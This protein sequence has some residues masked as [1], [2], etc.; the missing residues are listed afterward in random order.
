MALDKALEKDLARFKRY[1]DD[2]LHAD[3]GELEHHIQ[4]FIR[5]IQRNALVQKIIKNLP[6]F[7]A[8][9]WWDKH[10]LEPAKARHGRLESIH[11]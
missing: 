2:M 10:V 3:T 6:E 7:D 11:A 9:E 8:D 4:E 5:E 1:R